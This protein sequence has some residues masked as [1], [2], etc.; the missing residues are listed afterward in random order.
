MCVFWAGASGWSLRDAQELARQDVQHA[1]ASTHLWYRST[2]CWGTMGNL[3]GSKE[4]GSE[5]SLER[6][7]DPGVRAGLRAEGREEL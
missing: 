3:W 1:V 2:E 6:D 5:N 7:T 4:T